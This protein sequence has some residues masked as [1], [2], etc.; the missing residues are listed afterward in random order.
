MAAPWR[1]G[2]SSG[3][4]SSLLGL[5]GLSSLFRSLSQTNQTDQMNQLPATR[6][7]MGLATFSSHS[8]GLIR[9]NPASAGCDARTEAGH[10]RP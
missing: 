6:R 10:S 8:S 5:S 3:S 1:E 4:L 2:R 9:C 7:E